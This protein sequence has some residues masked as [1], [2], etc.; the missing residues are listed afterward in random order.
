[1]LLDQNFAAGQV[2]DVEGTPAAV[3]IDETGRVASEVA[4]GGPDV[5][6]LVGATRAKGREQEM[7]A[8][9]R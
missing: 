9:V 5:L 7:Q 4:V 6:A 3:M 8:S 2:F 1:V